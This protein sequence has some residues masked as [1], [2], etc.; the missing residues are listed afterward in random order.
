MA[1]H[2]E[3]AKEVKEPVAPEHHTVHYEPR[4]VEF[5]WVLYGAITLVCT[6]ATICVAVFFYHQAKIRAVSEDG[7]G[8]PLAPHPLSELP[9]K[10]R[11][12][13]L[14]KLSAE[15]A[16]R[17]YHRHDQMMQRLQSYGA[18]SQDGYLHVPIDR[19]METLAGELPVRKTSVKNS[20]RDNGLIDSG[21]PNSGRLFRKA[22]E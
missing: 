4:D 18:A 19:A 9:A 20:L 11:L 1:E 12:D 2:H 6:G 8:F 10:P 3:E 5:R 16:T 14:E 15:E 21:E 22:P 17:I 13:P 7:R